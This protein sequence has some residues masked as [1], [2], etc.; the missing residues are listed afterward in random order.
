MN[1]DLY[2]K[3]LRAFLDVENARSTLDSIRQ[4]HDKAEEDF[5]KALDALRAAKDDWFAAVQKEALL[6][7]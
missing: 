1:E 2:Q 5:N 7:S 3:L 6:A 4:Q